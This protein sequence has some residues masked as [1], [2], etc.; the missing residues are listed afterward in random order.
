MSIFNPFIPSYLDSKPF[1]LRNPYVNA[2]RN[3]A[4][5]ALATFVLFYV[6]TTAI[7]L[8]L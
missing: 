5:S 7:R 6:A 3:L 4:F 1:S 2:V 8:A